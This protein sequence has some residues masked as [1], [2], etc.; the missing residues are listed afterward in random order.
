M[1]KYPSVDEIVKIMLDARTNLDG[2]F[3]KLLDYDDFDTFV[4]YVYRDS[5]ADWY[6]EKYPKFMELHRLYRDAKNGKVRSDDAGKFATIVS[7]LRSALY[8]YADPTQVLVAL[9]DKGAIK[10]PELEHKLLQY[11]SHTRQVVARLVNSPYAKPIDFES[12]SR[13]AETPEERLNLA[14]GAEKVV[15][16]LIKEA[17]AQEMPDIYKIKLL[18]EQAYAAFEEILCRVPSEKKD[19]RLQELWDVM[20]DVFNWEKA[21]NEMT[22]KS[23]IEYEQTQAERI[24]Q[25]EKERNMYKQ[26]SELQSKLLENL[27]N[28]A[29]GRLYNIRPDIRRMIEEYERVGEK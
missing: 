25:L 5:R 1:N 29:S 18:Y 7:W 8:D 28:R 15:K 19:P 4:R 17:E 13:F 20:K 16:K 27:N 12:A 2:K 9:I 26:I 10:D 14:R 24:L 11:L 23:I 22:D 6:K 21:K 3:L